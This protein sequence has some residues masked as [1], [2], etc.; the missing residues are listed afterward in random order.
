VDLAWIDPITLTWNP[1]TGSQQLA[2]L[3]PNET[4]TVAADTNNHSI[5]TITSA[6]IAA[7]S[8]GANATFTPL[9]AG[10]IVISLTPPA[11]FGSTGIYQQITAT[12]FNP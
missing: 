8:S 3:T 12:V 6:T 1:V 11:N 5:G 7:G 4:L 10:S 9:A 2:A